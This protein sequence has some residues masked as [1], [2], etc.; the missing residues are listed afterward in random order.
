MLDFLLEGW[1]NKG[2]RTRANETARERGNW[3]GMNWIRQDKRLA[4]YLRDN[5]ACAYCGEG[6]EQGAKLTLDHV[7]P[8]AC[9]GSNHESNLV[10]CCS[11]CNSSRGKR[12]VRE[13]AAGVAEYRNHGLTAA[14]IIARVERLTRRSLKQ[15]REQA[16]AMIADRGSCAAA[17]AA[18]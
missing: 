16:K 8:H 9:G 10:T 13:F 17:V 3:Q 12:S 11:T 7:R 14:E 4:I 1:Q 15:Y 18:R 6:V 2:M 5:L